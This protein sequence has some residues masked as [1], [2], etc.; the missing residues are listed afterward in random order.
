M[1][2][3]IK[4][5]NNVV[6]VVETERDVVFVIRTKYKSEFWWWVVDTSDWN[7]YWETHNVNPNFDK[8]TQFCNDIDNTNLGCS[9]SAYKTV[10]EALLDADVLD[11]SSFE[12]Y[13]TKVKVNKHTLECPNGCSCL[14]TLCNG[15]PYTTPCGRAVEYDKE[16]N[17]VE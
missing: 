6:R 12:Y 3:R 16:G 15:D 17:E 8:A 5:E 11:K 10:E 7:S 9:C 4:P 1:D 13:V 2:K 14:G